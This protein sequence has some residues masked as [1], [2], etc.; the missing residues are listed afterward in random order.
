[1]AK[2][3]LAPRPP[4]TTHSAD[5]IF[6]IDERLSRAALPRRCRDFDSA[7]GPASVPGRCVSGARRPV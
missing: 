6:R 7:C 5:Q 4:A 2:A 3:R 1:M